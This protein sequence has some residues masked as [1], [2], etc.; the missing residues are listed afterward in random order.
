MLTNPSFFFVTVSFLSDYILTTL[1]V[2]I[3][4]FVF[5]IMFCNGQ[6]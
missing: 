2:D 4:V 6:R 1:Q 3:C 5:D